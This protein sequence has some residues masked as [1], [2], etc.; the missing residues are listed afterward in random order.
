MRQI[1]TCVSCGDEFTPPRS[2]Q[3]YCSVACRQRENKKH[4]A[5]RDNDLVDRS[6]DTLGYL[7][8]AWK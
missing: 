3:K 7:R 1:K 5:T 4:A 2:D 6:I 8:R